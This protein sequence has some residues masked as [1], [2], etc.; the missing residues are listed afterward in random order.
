MKL[1][2][3]FISSFLLASF[4]FQQISFAEVISPITPHLF[5]KLKV[6]LSIP[7]SIASVEDAWTPP[8]RG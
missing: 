8:Q 6:D 3:R 4:L 1:N 5:E 7:A 2:L